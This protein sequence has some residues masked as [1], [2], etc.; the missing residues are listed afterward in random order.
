MWRGEWDN[1]VPGSR[2]RA[3][4]CT[5]DIGEGGGGGRG[6]GRVVW[7]GVIKVGSRNRRTW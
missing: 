6:S 5:P 3:R 2:V 4:G 7:V 1:G